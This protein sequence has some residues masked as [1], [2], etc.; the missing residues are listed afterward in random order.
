MGPDQTKVLLVEDNRTVAQLLQETLLEANHA[1]FQMTH[2][3]R[4]SLAIDVLKR[5]RFDVIL[6]DLSLPD[7]RGL[8]T[9]D[10]IQREAR[11]IPIVVL[12][13]TD[14]ETIADEAIRR[15]AQDYLVKGQVDSRLVTRSIRYAIER[16]RSQ[17]E[18]EKFIVE[19]KQALAAVRQLQGMLPICTSCK[20]IRDDDGYWT[21]IE[22]YISEHSSASFS[23]G[24]CPRC[25]HKLYPKI[26]GQQPPAA[27]PTP[28]P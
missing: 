17:R 16:K 26:F 21:Q 20:R 11:L 15:G 8:D 23:H 24:L 6:L 7:S 14:N 19:L 12:T 1:R 9:V 10:R 27:Q 18:R 22:K 5:S 4:L 13:V 28:P 25:T 2:V 3:D